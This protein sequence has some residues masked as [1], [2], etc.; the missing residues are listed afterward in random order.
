[1]IIAEYSAGYLFKKDIG[2]MLFILVIQLDVIVC[3]SFYY[4]WKVKKLSN[5]EDL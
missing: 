3:Q 5:M 4:Q 2:F 1:M